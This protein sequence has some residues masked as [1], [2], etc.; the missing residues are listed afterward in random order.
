MSKES[1]RYTAAVKHSTRMVDTSTGNRNQQAPHIPSTIK[2]IPVTAV[3]LL[4]VKAVS[5]KLS[6]L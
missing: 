3:K 2:I 4:S 6:N 5:D 1:R